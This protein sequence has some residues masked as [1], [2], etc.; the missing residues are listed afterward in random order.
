VTID[1]ELGFSTMRGI[2]DGDY[3]KYY[4]H[5]KEV[6]R[7]VDMMTKYLRDQYEEEYAIVDKIWSML[8]RP[9]SKELAGRSIFDLI[10]ELL[11]K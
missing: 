9:S 6:D 5:V 10:Q 1:R 7:T 4:D 3:V 8:G 11:D 2:D